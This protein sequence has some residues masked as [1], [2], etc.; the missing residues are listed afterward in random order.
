MRRD[1]AAHAVR[2]TESA[3]GSHHVKALAC[4]EQRSA[5]AHCMVCMQTQ[6]RMQEMDMEITIQDT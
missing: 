2:P 4:A 1:I 3:F 5:R 6:Q